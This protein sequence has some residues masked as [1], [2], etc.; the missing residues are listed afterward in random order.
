[1][2]VETL[3][4][5]G[6]EDPETGVLVDENQEWILVKHIPVDYVIDGY[7]LYRKRFIEKRI[8]GEKEEKIEKVLKLKR[9][10]LDKPK[11]FQFRDTIGLLE[12]VEKSYGIFEFQD[13]DGTEVAYGKINK[14]IDGLLVIDFVDADGNVEVSY[15]CEYLIKDIRVITFQTDYHTSVVLLWKDNIK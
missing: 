4:I 10:D 11:G 2:R 1:M 14:I 5:E 7:K 3:Y 15:D 9:I 12:W 8:N 6:F 13:L